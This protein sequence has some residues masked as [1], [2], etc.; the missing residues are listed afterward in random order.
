MN[1]PSDQEILLEA[2]KIQDNKESLYIFLNDL[3]TQS[4]LE[5]FASRLQVAIMLEN[6]DTYEIIQKKTKL[7]SR[8][9]SRVAKFLN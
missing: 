7:S 9:I 6:K 4:E 1:I 3:L 8:T 5:E 2:I